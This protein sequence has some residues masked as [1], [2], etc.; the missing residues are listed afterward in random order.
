MP[1]PL[2]QVKAETERLNIKTL[3]F[4]ERLQQLHTDKIGGLLVIIR[5]VSAEG[6]GVPFLMVI[7]AP[8][9]V[10]FNGQGPS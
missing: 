6:H 5:M 2:D 10:M 4:Q 9:V 1:E 3:N 7:A 8:S